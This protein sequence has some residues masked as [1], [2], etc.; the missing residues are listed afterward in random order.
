MSAGEQDRRPVPASTAG[1]GMDQPLSFGLGMIT[2]QHDPRDQRTDTQI[3]ADVLSLSEL[4]EELGYDAVWLSEHHFVDDGYMPSLLPVAAAIAVRTS[5]IR[6]GTGILV[7][8][9]HDPIRLA[10]DAATVDLLSGG[11]LVL[12]IGAG[13]RDEE[14]AGFGRAKSGLG[15]RLDHTLEVLGAA[16]S[17]ER[18]KADPDAPGV[19]VTPRPDRAGGPPVWIGAR[20]PAGIRRAARRAS[21]LMAARVTPD[22]L[23]ALVTDFAAEVERSGRSTGDVQI[24]MHCPVLAWPDGPTSAWD[25]LEP[26]IHY[27]EWKYKDMMGTPFGERSAGPATPSTLSDSGREALKSGAL[28][29]TPEQVADAVRPFVEA[30]GDVPFHFVPRLYWPGME[31]SLQREAIAVFAEQVIPLLR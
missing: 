22:E 31:S 12:G 21:G 30:A 25:R 5:R 4:A 17:G 6:V 23:A 16:W 3:Y 10:E 9:L 2:A 8:P 20:T 26:F 27:S 11:R 28:V 14:F 29:G 7:A 13:Y 15:A 18:V 1:A 19:L 24:G